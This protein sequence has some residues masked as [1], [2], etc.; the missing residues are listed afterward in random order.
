MDCKINGCDRAATYKKAQVC[1]MHYFRFMR[2]GKYD[3]RNPKY[4]IVNPAGYHFL[5]EPLHDM[6]DNRGYV[7][8]HRFV[9]FNEFGHSLME[10]SLCKKPWLWHGGRG[11]HV[12]HVDEDITNNHISN[13]R[14]LCNSCNTRRGRKQEHEY[15]HVRAIEYKGKT[16]T[17]SQWAKE[18]FV[19]VAHYTIRNRLRACWSIEKALTKPSQKSKI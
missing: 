5:Y 2:T 11:S 17:A 9:L 1:Q 13:L 18:D 10:C 19:P 8:V 4:R 14:P 6:A 7:S 16:M 3:K 12:D 15:D